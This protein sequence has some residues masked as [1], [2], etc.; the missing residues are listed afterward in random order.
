MRRNNAG[1]YPFHQQRAES[2]KPTEEGGRIGSSDVKRTCTVELSELGLNENGKRGPTEGDHDGDKFLSPLKLVPLRNPRDSDGIVRVPSP[3]VLPPA[4]L[5]RPVA[6]VQKVFASGASSAG[7]TVVIVIDEEDE[8]KEVQKQDV[9]FVVGG[10]GGSGCAGK[11]PINAKALF[12]DGKQKGG[13]EVDGGGEVGGG[14][15]SHSLGL[16]RIEVGEKIRKDEELNLVILVDESGSM[17]GDR[18]KRVMESL[19][20]VRNVCSYF[21]VCWLFLFFVSC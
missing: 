16:L 4:A 10:S 12:F 15:I 9:V 7:K 5:L 1:S 11:V 8:K 3:L 13:G 14:E 6:K 17:S 21:L 19:D 2:P 20:A 18:L